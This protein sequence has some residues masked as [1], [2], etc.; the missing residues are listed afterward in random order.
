[1]PGHLHGGDGFTH[2][3]AVKLG[4]PRS[5]D[6]VVARLAERFR[7][8]LVIGC[9]GEHARLRFVEDLGGFGYA[10]AGDGEAVEHAAIRNQVCGFVA[11]AAV[12][13]HAAAIACT[14]VVQ[15]AAHLIRI[16]E[17]GRVRH[18]ADGASVRRRCPFHRHILAQVPAHS[19][20]VIIEST[21][22]GQVDILPP[23]I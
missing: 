22:V 17:L 10:D 18:I 9:R 21:I 3:G 8:V 23:D 19:G 14:T 12:G 11:H 20:G 15:W 5:P 4:N 13:V 6:Q 7:Q 16:I 1:M 2:V